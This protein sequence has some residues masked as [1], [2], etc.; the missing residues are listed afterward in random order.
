MDLFNGERWVRSCDLEYEERW[1][2][3]N[4]VSLATSVRVSIRQ[5]KMEIAH[6]EAH[7]DRLPIEGKWSLHYKLRV[8]E[9]V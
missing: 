5:G 8:L 3:T 1:V 6:I 7:G 2:C 9:A 4:P